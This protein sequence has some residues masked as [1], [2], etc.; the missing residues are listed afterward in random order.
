MN[1]GKRVRDE[2]TLRIKE[3]YQTLLAEVTAYHDRLQAELQDERARTEPYGHLVR[4]LERQ[5][6]RVERFA[7]LLREDGLNAV[8]DITNTSGYVS[9]ARTRDFF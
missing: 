5:V 3:A 7:D 8:L 6:E 2:E 4:A 9:H 1:P